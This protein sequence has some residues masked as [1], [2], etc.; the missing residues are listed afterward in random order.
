METGPLTEPLT[1]GLG[2]YTGQR[3]AGATGHHYA[4]APVL[5]AAAEAAGFHAFWISEHHAHDDGYLPSPLPVVAACAAATSRIVLG[6]GLLLAPL[7]DPVRLATD[8]M[9][10]DQLSGGRLVLGL[11]LGY[12]DEEYRAFGVE[13]RM[14]AARLRETVDILRLAWTGERFSYEGSVLHVDDIRVTPRPVRPEGIPIW[15]GGYAPEAIRRAARVADGHLI[16]RGAPDIIDRAL[17]EI[18][19]AQAGATDR[20]QAVRA[21]TI[22][23]N[24]AVAL[25]TPDGHADEARRAFAAQQAGYERI[26]RG[27]DVY[28]GL[29]ADADGPDGGPHLALGD[30]SRYLQAD[31]SADD[32]VDAVRQV[33]LRLRSQ[34]RVHIVLRALFPEASVD[35]QLSRI[36]A[37]GRDVLPRLTAATA[38]P[39][40]D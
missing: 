36:A 10:V 22:G 2:L 19:S 8:A 25:R 35:R 39:A 11:G 33:L 5:A 4:D 38:P 16:G 37:L 15:L 24:L 6:T 17:Q 7:Y 13:R 9:V 12:V 29:V 40:M 21:L 18:S 26:Q 34:G 20:Q 1:F 27:R 32:I 31:G 14:R 28:A 30:I 23:V 3:P